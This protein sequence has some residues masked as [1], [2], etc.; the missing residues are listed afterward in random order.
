MHI[1]CFTDFIVRLGL[2]LSREAMSVTLPT[3]NFTPN[4]NH[5]FYESKATL[6]AN[7]ILESE[8]REKVDK[9]WVDSWP[10]S[11]TSS[12]FDAISCND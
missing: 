4:E 11:V 1:Q 10:E 9:K 6:I 8:L 2:E 5:R 3:H 7:E 12:R